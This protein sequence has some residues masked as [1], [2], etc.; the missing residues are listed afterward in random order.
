MACWYAAGRS[1]PLIFGHELAAADM[2]GDR[3]ALCIEAKAARILPVGGHP[4]IGHKF[5]GFAAHVQ[6]LNVP[7]SEYKLFTLGCSQVKS[8]F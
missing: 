7:F 6:N 8:T 2:R 1:R 4:V 3:L 5:L